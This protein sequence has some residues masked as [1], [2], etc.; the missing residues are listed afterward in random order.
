VFKNIAERLGSRCANA[1]SAVQTL[2]NG[3][4]AMLKTNAVVWRL[5]GVLDSM[6]WGLL[7][8]HGRVVGTL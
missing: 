1:S 5:H 2:R 4:N 3:Q 8:R 6:L 7:E